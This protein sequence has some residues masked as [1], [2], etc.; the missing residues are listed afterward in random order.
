MILVD[1]IEIVFNPKNVLHYKEKGYNIPISKDNK[2]R[3]RVPQGSKIEVFVKDLPKGSHVRIPVKCDYCGKEYELSYRD[4][5]KH[6]DDELGSCCHKCEGIKY[7]KTMLERYG[8]YSSYE[9]VEFKEKA[10]KTNREKYGCDWHTQRPEYQEY[11]TGLFLEKYGVERPLQDQNIHAKMMETLSNNGWSKTSKPQREIYNILC[12]LYPDNCYIEFPCDKC[13]LDCMVE[14]DGIKIDIEYDG[15]YW[16]EK[17]DK[18]DRRRDNFVKSKGYKILRIKGNKKDEIPS[19]S[20][21]SSAI[22]VLLYSL[23]K[24]NE[25]VM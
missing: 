24:Y 16:H 20:Q 13:L 11:L 22:E 18:S 1:K 4:Y 10:I 5:L 12:E 8:A 14:I 19:K 15:K 23:K 25:I 7:K 3:L 2:G 9:I 21:L 6:C 17:K